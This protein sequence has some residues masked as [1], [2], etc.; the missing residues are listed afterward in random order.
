MDETLKKILKHA[1]ASLVRKLLIMVATWLIAKG[2]ISDEQ[3]GQLAAADMA[4]IV[5]GMIIVAAAVGWGWL[6]VWHAN[7]KLNVAIASSP[8]MSRK[9]FES[10][11]KDGDLPEPVK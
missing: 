6:K 7:R 4:E 11:Y 3:G 5:L 10:R 8:D 9:E 2:L 1:A